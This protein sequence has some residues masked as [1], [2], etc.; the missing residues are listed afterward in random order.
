M[1]KL[2]VKHNIKRISE[3]LV[4]SKKFSGD[5]IYYFEELESTNSW[6]L[7]RNRYRLDSQ[8]N[9]QTNSQS[10]AQSNSQIDGKICLTEKQTAG[11]GRRGKSWIANTSSSVLLSIGWGLPE[12]GRQA[13]SLV[14]GLAVIR[15]L[16]E[17]GVEGI[18]LKWPNDVIAD[19]KKLGG[20]LVEISARDCVIGVA[21]NVN[22]PSSFDRYIDQPWTDL[23]SLGFQIDRD[24]L[25]A[26]IVLNH[27]H[28]LLQ[29]Q[30]DGFASFVDSWNALHV[31]QNQLVDVSAVGNCLSG[32][33][34][35]VDAEGALLVESAGVI[36]RIICGDVS[37]R[38]NSNRH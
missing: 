10:N 24:Q 30:R 23:W 13:L 11:K 9:S 32:T 3:L 37:V 25:V 2:A 21:I 1:L 36:K 31:Y 16:Q 27:E 34:L 5:G 7:A 33:A 38:A 20:I 35:G 28:F 6:L 26:A 14:S 8:T 4:I 17:F 15:A 22:M 12:S 19:G 18:K 29:C